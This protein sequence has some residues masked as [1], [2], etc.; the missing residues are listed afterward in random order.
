MSQSSTRPMGS[1]PLPVPITLPKPGLAH[2]VVR[3]AQITLAL[4]RHLVPLAVR[5]IMRRTVS[6][7]EAARPLR[8]VFQDLGSTF[9]KLGQLMGSAPGLFGEAVAAEFRSCLDQAPPVPFEDVRR[10]VEAEL[11]RPLEAAFGRFDRTPIAAASIAVVHAA[12]L[13][14]GEKVAVKVLRPGIEEQV[15]TDLALMEPLVNGIVRVVGGGIGAPLRQILTGFR[16]Q[17]A[18]ELDL[19][20]ETLAIR[21]HLRMLEEVDLPRLLLPTPVERL[22]GRRV[23]TMTFIEGVPIDDIAAIEE[24]GVDPRPIVEEVVR[25]WFLTT[26]RNG[27]FHG[28]VHAGNLLFTPDGRLGIVD[29]GIVGRLDA[30]T[31]DFFRA[32]VEASLGREEAWERIVA[33]VEHVYGPAMREGLGLDDAA[34]DRMVRMQVGQILLQP[35]GEVRLSDLV[36]LRPDRAAAASQDNGSSPPPRPK[37][38]RERLRRLREQR[39]AGRRLSAAAEE[40]GLLESNMDRGMFLLGKQLLYFERYGK[41]YLSDMSLLEDKAFFTI[42]LSEDPLAM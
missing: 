39:R 20:N 14:G 27:T 12:W 8:D 37:G 26:I 38:A 13:P 28:D 6:D 36:L 3:C 1:Y 32:I 2:L 21:H 24:L 19:R 18:E 15:A 42:A 35:F 34:I 9:L 25:A 17:V 23:L 30:E 41:M 5:R 16:E 40:S 29:W 11:G 4:L 22:S 33:H 7:A 10:I 31:H